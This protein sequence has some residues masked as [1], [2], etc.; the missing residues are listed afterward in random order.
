MNKHLFLAALALAFTACGQGEAPREQAAGPEAAPAAPAAAP[1]PEIGAWGIDLTAMD[2]AASPG[3]DFHRYVNGHWLDTFVMPA[4]K[5]R[6][7]IFDALRER[8]TEQVHEIIAELAASEP[9]DGSLEQKVGDFYATWMDVGRLNELG[10]APLQP[11]LD[12]LS[13]IEDRDD[14]MMAFATVH[15]MAPFGVGIIPDPADTTRYTVFAG[16]SGLGMPDRDYY[17]LD[18]ARFVEFRTAYRDYVVRIQELAGIEDAAAR[19]DAIIALETRLAEKHW[20]QAESRDIQKIY[21]PMT[22]A[23]LQAL[24]P[25]FAWERMLDSLGLAGVEP[26][27]VAQPSVMTAAGEMLE[28]V[29]VE[30]WKDYLTYHFIRAN[31]Q[32]LAEDFDEAHFEFYSRTLNGIEAQRERWKRGADFVNANLG[33]AV[34]KIYVER[35]FPPD[36]K[37][38]MDELVANLRAAL[39]E[40]LANNEWMDDETR[41]QALAKLATFEARIG[42]TE[43]WTDYGPLEIEAGD[44]LGNALRVDD[45][46]WKEQLDRL[47]GPVDRALWPYPPQTVNASY[48]PLLNQIT[49]P[50][51]ILQPPFFDPHADAAVN[52]GAIGGVIGHEIGH[53]FDD[54]GRRFDEQ[55]RI[56]DWWTETADARFKERSGKLVEQY[57]GYSPIEGMT[58]NGSLTLGENIGDVGGLSMAYAAYQRYVAAH[59]EPPVIDGLTGDQRF[60]MSW[61]Q[62]WRSMIREDALRQR[63]VT[64]PHSPAEYRVNGVVRNIDAWYEAFDVGP[65]AALYLPPE[66]RVRIW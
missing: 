35:H 19:A 42:Y 62:V 25:Q 50:A 1:T 38:Q 16:Q 13:A 46:L 14:V 12:A 33:E 30:T 57:N 56:R 31:A 55:G 17:L 28:T 45:F 11:H 49:F 4:D 18:D 6:Y 64:D 59:G 15:N 61:A 24:A 32:F 3:D 52:Y 39:E 7:G 9:A 60:F 65:E 43:K 34:G 40:R 41:Q 5:A 54:Q 44:M 66:E 47:G 58:V 27:V 20:T 22:V 26:I 10:A 2:P 8:S 37:A 29:P 21:N 48:N 53:G 63:L 23:E 36:A 51:G